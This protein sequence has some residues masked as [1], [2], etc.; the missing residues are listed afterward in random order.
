MGMNRYSWRFGPMSNSSG[1]ELRTFRDSDGKEWAEVLVEEFVEP[2]PKSVPKSTPVEPKENP[3][4]GVQPKGEEVAVYSAP[5]LETNYPGEEFNLTRKAQPGYKVLPTPKNQEIPKVPKSG[6]PEPPTKRRRVDLDTVEGRASPEHTPEPSLTPASGSSGLVPS[7]PLPAS[8]IAGP[9]QKNWTV[10]VELP[11][12]KKV[13]LTQSTCFWC[14]ISLN[15]PQPWKIHKQI[16]L[17]CSMQKVFFETSSWIYIPTSIRSH[18][19]FLFGDFAQLP[20]AQCHGCTL[21]VSA[22]SDL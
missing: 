13:A 9:A 16:H 8:P 12:I 18:E 15:L 5:R 21:E 10:A 14:T 7:P 3:E 4:A 6:L 17:S 1:S 11:A 20:S 2:T 22:H 19:V